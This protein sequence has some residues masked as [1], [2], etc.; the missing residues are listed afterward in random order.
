VHGGK[1][2]GVGFRLGYEGWKMCR[3]I[4]SYWVTGTTA[5]VGAPLERDCYDGQ[6]G[7]S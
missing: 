5:V 4:L 6:R 7:P 1:C 2:C 3:K